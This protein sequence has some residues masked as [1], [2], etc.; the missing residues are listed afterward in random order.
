MEEDDYG[1]DIRRREIRELNEE[2]SHI[3]REFKVLARAKSKTYERLIEDLRAQYKD[4]ILEIEHVEDVEIKLEHDPESMAGKTIYFNIE[5]DFDGEL[6]WEE[7]DSL[8]KT[9]TD[10]VKEIVLKPVEEPAY[11]VYVNLKFGDVEL[12]DSE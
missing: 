8:R 1:E 11:E 9:I 12:K 6:I 2:I 7:W 5:H 4:D 10:K 3:D